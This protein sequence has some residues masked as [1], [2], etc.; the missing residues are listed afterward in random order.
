MNENKKEKINEPKVSQL[1]MI[2]GFF[3]TPIVFIFLLFLIP[4]LMYQNNYLKKIKM[5]VPYKDSLYLPSGKLVK[6]LALGFDMA[7]ADFLWL[8]SIQSFGGHYFGDKDFKAIFN[9]FDVITELDPYFVDAY[10]FGNLVIGDEGGN[11]EEALVLLDKG[12]VKMPRNYKLA[13]E[14]LYISNWGLKDKNRAKR[15]AVLAKRDPN[16]PD[17][18]ERIAA[19]LERESGRYEVAF[20]KLLSQLLEFYGGSEKMIASINA[21]KMR[22]TIAEWQVKILDKA[23]KKFAEKEG[24]DPKTLEELENSGC[25]DEYTVPDMKKLFLAMDSYLEQGAKL[26]ANMEK[27]REFCMVKSN[28]IPKT[29]WDDLEGFVIIPET[30]TKND[31]FILDKHKA[32]LKLYEEILPGIRARIRVYH[33]K[34]GFYPPTISDAYDEDFGIPE[35]F[36]GHWIYNQET[37]D[38]RSSTFPKI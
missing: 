1:R 24:R 9:L 19:T 15:Y 26:P 25:I 5:E 12:I 30:T 11:Q 31:V 2:F 16:C 22:E 6:P 4:T 7:L 17:Y 23:A 33:E 20:D 14:A 8:R 28:K 37:G 35:P 29:P 36:G 13:Y 38:F 27:I 3:K 21:D 18:I 34:H 10:T 32:R